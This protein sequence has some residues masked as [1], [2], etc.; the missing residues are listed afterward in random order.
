MDLV[1]VTPEDFKTQDAH[2]QNIIYINS[3]HYWDCDEAQQ[4]E[5]PEVLYA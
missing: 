3:N 4:D 2:L 1:F 5:E